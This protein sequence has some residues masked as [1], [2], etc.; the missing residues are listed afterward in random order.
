MKKFVS[1]TVLLCMLLSM[2]SVASAEVTAAD[3]VAQIAAISGATIENEAAIDAAYY[4]YYQLPEEERA[5]VTNWDALLALREDLPKL[6]IVGERQGTNLPWHKL[7]IGT[8]CYPSVL[9]NE[10]DVKTLADA[11]IDFIAAA[12]YNE[13]LMNLLQQYGVGAFV[14]ASSYG[15][16]GYNYGGFFT[17]GSTYYEYAPTHTAEDMQAAAETN[18]VLH[19]AVWGI[20][21]KDEPNAIEF[22]HQGRDMAVLDEMFPTMTSY[23]NLF[24][25]YATAGHLGTVTY[26]QYIRLLHERTDIDYTCY[27]HYMYSA[28]ERKF[29]NLAGYINNLDVVSSVG[30]ELGKETWIVIQANSVTD[31]APLG[32]NRMKLQAYVA[33][34]FGAKSLNWACWSDAQGWFNYQVTDA[35]GNP[36]QRYYDVQAINADLHALGPVFM[37]YTFD[38]TCAIG[39]VYAV[40]T[41]GAHI[42]AEINLK[43]DPTTSGIYTQ[44]EFEAMDTGVPYNFTEHGE[45]LYYYGN[46]ATKLSK[47]RVDNEYLTKNDVTLGQDV[48]AD[49]A[50]AE[51]KAAVLIGGFHKSVGEGSAVMLVNISNINFTKGSIYEQRD[52]DVPA[53]VTFRVNDPDAVVTVYVKGIPT[54]LEPV[55][56]VY[57]VALN[58]ADAA[59]VTV[60]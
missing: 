1:L 9:W 8:Y 20:E 19:P 56:G 49:F 59:F 6:Y 2:M 42:G 21:L 41:E 45:G 13:E 28:T 34:A 46:M 5:N 53:I 58:T 57:T 52:I 33:L 60:E 18:V 48:F 4:A 22:I 37:R 14:N 3:V 51:P 7:R 31:K 54:V 23:I 40:E 30:K 55:D 16:P 15:L 10:E 38:T 25:N 29:G 43:V 17:T 50:V 32:I 47:Y 44:E 12:S 35:E 26:E 36:T 39:D 27:D 11:G 24:P